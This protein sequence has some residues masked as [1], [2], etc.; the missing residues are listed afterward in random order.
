VGS[1][2]FGGSNHRPD[3]RDTSDIVT[4]DIRQIPCIKSSSRWDNTSD[5]LDSAWC[6]IVQDLP[7]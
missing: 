5:L 3:L 2:T 6:E 4:L 7:V 1:V